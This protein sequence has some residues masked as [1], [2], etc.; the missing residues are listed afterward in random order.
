MNLSSTSDDASVT[1]ALD[2]L[3]ES[4]STMAVDLQMKE[5]DQAMLQVFAPYTAMHCN[6]M[7]CNAMHCTAMQD[8][9]RHCT[10]LH[11]TAMYCNAL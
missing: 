8:T 6:A 9:A 3:L 11:H 2:H 4:W 10:T 1:E 7:H 5:Q